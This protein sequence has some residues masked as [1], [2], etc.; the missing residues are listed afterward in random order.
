MPVSHQ[1]RAHR[2]VRELAAAERPGAPLFALRAEVTGPEA[3]VQRGDQVVYTQAPPRL[4]DAVVWVD[5][6]GRI[7]FGRIQR[8]GLVLDGRRTHTPAKFRGV[9][10]A[11]MAAL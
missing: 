5:K 11:V 1:S 9:I 8:G 7:R 4:D 3:S 10:I 6:D 2:L